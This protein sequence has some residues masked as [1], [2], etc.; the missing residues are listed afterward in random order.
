MCHLK[1]LLELN[2]SGES[3]SIDD[4]NGNA[5]LIC[6]RTKNKRAARA[7]RTSRQIPCRPPQNNNVNLSVSQLKFR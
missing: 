4:V 7:V 6:R 3:F 5:N 2:L 1:T